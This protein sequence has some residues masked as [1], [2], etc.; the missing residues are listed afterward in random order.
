VGI[1]RI[2]PF[3]AGTG[4]LA[5]GAGVLAGLTAWG[6]SREVVAPPR[7]EETLHV[8]AATVQPGDYPVTLTAFG[9]VTPRRAVGIAAEVSGRVVEMHPQFQVGGRVAD[10]DVLFRIDPSLYETQL[11]EAEALLRQQEAALERLRAEE[12]NARTRAR[13]AAQ[14]AAL[15]ERSLE[16]AREMLRKGIG[17]RSDVDVSEL[18]AVEARS[19]RDL[20]LQEAETFPV[21]IREVMA[22][23]DAARA[24]AERARQ[25]LESTFVRAPF[26]GRVQS[27]QVDLGQFVATGLEV[28]ALVDDSVLE[29]T[30]P[31]ESRVARQWLQFAEE[32]PAADGAWFPELAR[33]DCEIRWTEDTAGPAWRGQVDRIADYDPASRMVKVV[34]TYTPGSGG[35]A[36]PLV[37][38][39]FC[40]VD[41]PGRT[42]DGVYRLPHEAVTFDDHVYTVVNSRLKAAPVKVEKQ[43]GSFTYVS[44]GLKPGDTVV[45]TRLVDALDNTLLQVDMTPIE[46]A[47][48][49][50][51]ATTPG[52]AS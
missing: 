37:A 48:V 25:S 19:Q 52:A 18:A 1:K 49:Q 2:A 40:R 31:L 13:A 27:T 22:G 36:F 15:S 46:T 45:V 41:I 38:G 30:V 39:M 51:E 16:R 26:A 4:I 8:R 12:G 24:A 29:I 42:L 9:Q 35:D 17:S 34:V 7:Q 32:F 50:P 28:A 14:S 3:L 23:V 44:A 21:R 20:A 43:E 33:V 10:G 5:A 47:A 6:A 11:A